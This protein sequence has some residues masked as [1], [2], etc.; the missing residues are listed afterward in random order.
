MKKIVIENPRKISIREDE[1]PKIEEGYAILRVLYGGICGSDL[2]SYRGSFAYFEYPRTP[3]HELSAEIVEIEDNTMGLKPGMLV[4]VNPYFNC[5]KCY[6]CRRGIVN[7]CTSN[8]TMG[9]QREG[10]FSEYIKMPI[11]RLYNA[12][13]LTAKQAVLIEPFCIGWHGV[14]RGQVKQGDKVLVIGAGTIGV[15]T[16]LAAKAKGAEVYVSDVVEDKLK[17][18]VEN[19]GLD[20]YILNDS[21][22]NFKE[23]VNIITNGDGFD[24]CLEAVGLASTFQLCI[25]SVAFGGNVVLIGV[26][27]QKL[28]FDFTIIQKKELNIYGSRNALKEDFIELIELVKNDVVNIDKV[29]T[30]IYKFEDAET[31][32]KDFDESNRG[33]ML[34]VLLDFTKGET[35]EK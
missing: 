21:K 9:V 27:K 17:M 23:K 5:G 32:F 34:K 7:A 13:G 6:S 8:Q 16:A 10:G 14:N 20:G 12:E 26:S 4:T 24:V 3:G 1:M 35:N 11:E 22:D 25:E 28:D 31:A 2:G 33:I 30:N 19:F 18:V 29:I 15:F